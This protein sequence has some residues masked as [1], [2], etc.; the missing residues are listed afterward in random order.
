MGQLMVSVLTHLS[1]MGAGDPLRSKGPMPAGSG[2]QHKS[3][4]GAKGLNANRSFCLLKLETRVITRCWDQC[5]SNA[6]WR[7]GKCPHFDLQALRRKWSLG[8]IA[9]SLFVATKKGEMREQSTF[10][11]FD[12]RGS[13]LYLYCQDRVDGCSLYYE[14]SYRQKWLHLFTIHMWALMHIW[15]LSPRVGRL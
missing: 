2:S 3:G 4:V 1:P 6:L 15:R 10:S 8:L 13:I 7:R 11:A 14:G 9:L 12:S 5:L